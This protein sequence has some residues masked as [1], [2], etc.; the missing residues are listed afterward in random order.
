MA[1][2]TVE[3]GDLPAGTI[4]GLVFEDADGDGLPDDDQPGL[5]GVQVRITGNGLHPHLFH[6]CQRDVPI[7]R[8]PARRLH[9]RQNQ[10]LPVTAARRRPTRRSILVSG[11]SA[12]ANF[13]EHITG[14][15][16]G[17]VYDDLDGNGVQE[18]HEPGLAGVTVRL[19]ATA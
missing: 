17:I 11:G 4:S 19:L 2:P 12:S 16:S 10:S 5:S 6:R 9:R 3:F 8:G 18:S 14:T 15:V 7:H 1:P 13:G